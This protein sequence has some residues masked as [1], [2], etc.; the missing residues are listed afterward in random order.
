MNLEVKRITIDEIRLDTNANQN[1]A[2][3][4]EN[5]AWVAANAGTGKTHVLT[6]RVLRLLLAGTRPERILCLTFTKAAAAE[7]SKRVF[8]RLA[9]WVTMNDEA[10]RADLRT[11][12]ASEPSG[13]LLARARTLFAH[14][15]ETPGGL[16]VQ[17]IHAFAERLLQ[18]FPIEA[19]VAP[20]F[21]ILDDV[22]AGDLKADAIEAVLTRATANPMS[23]LGEALNVIIRYAAD[24]QF[25]QL[26]SK[27]VEER[28][29]LEAAAHGRSPQFV[30]ELRA[31]DAFLRRELRVRSGVAASDLH[32]E[33][34]GVL[35]AAE[36]R[37]LCELLATG[38]SVDN[39]HGTKLAQALA[40]TD[41]RRKAEL[42]ADY[43]LIEKGEAKRKSLLAKALAQSKPGLHDRC[44]R[45]QE[46]FFE[47]TQEL[48]ALALVEASLAL[49]Q[50]AGHVLR[51]YAAARNAAGALDFDDLILKTRDLLTS[52]NGQTKWVLFKLDGGLDHIL[53]DEAQDTSP[54]QW[55]IVAALA[56][57]FFSDVGAGAMTRTVFA[58]GD[59]KQSIYSFQGA[60]P[61]MFA[62][63]GQTFA[64]LAMQA[65][66]TWKRIP[67]TL[68]F[69][70]VAP[71]LSAVDLVFRD[72]TRAPGL[73]ADNSAVGHVAN[74]IGHAG[75]VEIW[76]TE[77]F[78]DAPDADPWQPLSD[79]KEQSP[80][81]RLADRIADTIKTW[82]ANKERL[83]SENRPITP[84]DILIL[85]RKR[86]PFAVPMVAALKRRG[87]AVAG[88]DRV[89][90]MDQIAVQDLMVLGDFL[91][92]PEDDLALATVLK[93]PLFDLDDHDL[94]AITR[95]R[96]AK[97]LW[98]ALIDR[99]G[100]KPEFAFATETLK[101]WRAKAD[102]MPPFEFFAG[103]LERDGMRER[104]L[105]RLGLEAA[106]VIDEFLDLALSYDESDPPSLTQ[107]LAKLRAANPEVKRDM[108]H[109]RD[110]VRVMTVHGAKGLEAPIVFLPD[111]CT[112]AS[113]EDAV[114]RLIKLDLGGPEE[115]PQPIVWTVKGTSKIPAVANARAEKDAREAEERNRLL[116][117]AMTRARDRLYISGFEGKKG[118]AA[119]CWYELMSDAL[120]PT[121]TEIV[122]DNGKKIWRRETPQVAAPE[123]PK[124]EKGVA[125]QALARPDFANTRAPAEPKL[126]VPL[127]P[128]R[129]E[130]YAPDLEGEP[131]FPPKRDAGS[132]NDNPSPLA[133]GGADRFLRGTI[134]HALLQ[135]L[136]EVDAKR[137]A[138]IA[139][140]FVEKRG[141][142]LGTKIRANIVS[143]TLAVLRDPRFHAIFGPGSVAEAPLAAVIPRP[144]GAG[145]ALDL[146]GQIDRIAITDDEVLIVDYKTNRPPPAEVHQV[147]DAYL[148]Q[149]AAY[150][151][152]LSE[153]YPDKLVRAAL[154]WTDGPRLMEVPANVLDAFT[155]RLWSLDLGSLDA[156]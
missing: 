29:W 134:T 142:A 125:G 23:P 12:T 108:D 131:S 37:E 60:A 103:I 116:Y 130:P 15:I 59:E 101:R 49:Y 50:V 88:S 127:A 76:E 17:T 94:L 35:S 129:L 54:E 6:L 13:D 48:R 70:T 58:V 75:L 137:W 86:M 148:Y 92:L 99:S 46:N 52:E 133:S 14:A 8:D 64:E 113:G 156:V 143:E 53:V 135:H 9:S 107:F 117:V 141:A 19:G 149:L 136:P 2:S 119:G 30:E 72:P 16:K 138:E 87:I 31:M 20:D 114:S 55:E 109:G 145:P 18:R 34:A 151:L 98:R 146:S 71:V 25:D 91:T 51:H 57:E 96:G 1:A 63:M 110:E 126:S 139:T 79:V 154:L 155:T 85:V 21:K 61:E 69:R 32:S 82:I 39:G 4:P 33:C 22:A 102:F 104:M 123:K 97:T 120:T 112:T 5:S 106:D 74:R 150:R 7:M 81:N 84:G 47:L 95:E 41:H 152:A 115:L 100:D 11:V 73:T 140:S 56:K 66:R 67:L 77:K 147:A 65:E 122:G 83:Q 132:T 105:N 121:M 28:K 3:H 89:R 62:K 44:Q 27:A 93:S 90:L 78:E 36:L 45:A 43:F 111:T 40:E 118:R 80:A 128:S 26:I 24:S 68:S 10:L 144:S 124:H 38:G 42:L 153:I